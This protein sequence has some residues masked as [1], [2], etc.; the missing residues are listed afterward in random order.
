[1]C[2]SRGVIVVGT[3]L[4]RQSR[5]EFRHQADQGRG[6]RDFREDRHQFSGACRRPRGG[7]A[8][9][10]RV[11]WRANLGAIFTFYPESSIDA[12]FPIAQGPNCLTAMF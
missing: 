11:F 8:D 5:Q 3:S 10:G 2:D 7:R 4:I 12:R 6:D 1:M 9:C